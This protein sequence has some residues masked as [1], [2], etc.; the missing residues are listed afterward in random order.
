MIHRILELCLNLLGRF[1]PWNLFVCGLLFIVGLL[2]L[3]FYLDKKKR[4]AAQLPTPPSKHKSP[5]KRSLLESLSRLP[6]DQYTVLTQVQAPRLDGLGTTRLQHVVLSIY[7]IFIIHTQDQSGHV[8][9]EDDAP[10]WSVYGE[11]G[12][13]TFINPIIRNDYHV[14][15]AAKYLG[16]P[17][18]LF[19]S[20]IFFR[21]EVHFENPAHPNIITTGLGRQILSHSTPIISPEVLSRAIIELRARAN[22]KKDDSANLI[23][24]ADRF[25]RQTR[26]QTKVSGQ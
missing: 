17:D 6:K 10:F 11:G 15:A 24:N 23:V 12:R 5:A 16:L 22:I 8:S 9:N 13:T 20:I 14:R 4:Q 26:H 3:E 19:F 1:W 2:A 21:S 18:A 7:G 25:I